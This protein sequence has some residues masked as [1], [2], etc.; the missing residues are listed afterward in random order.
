MVGKSL[1][2]GVADEPADGDID[3]SFTHQF[4]VVDDPEQKT[5][6]H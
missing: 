2:Q 3:V 1:V 4:A 6:Q 5:G